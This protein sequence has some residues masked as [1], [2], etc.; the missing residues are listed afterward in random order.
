MSRP[1]A[2]NRARRVPRASPRQWGNASPQM[3]FRDYEYRSDSETFPTPLFE[4]IPLSVETSFRNRD[5]FGQI[6]EIITN[7]LAPSG[8]AGAVTVMDLSPLAAQ[9]TRI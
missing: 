8:A 5:Q 7:V 1:M 6:R 3:S 2:R 9:G 4:K